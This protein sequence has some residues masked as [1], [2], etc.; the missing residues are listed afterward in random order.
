MRQ[1]R[2]RFWLRAAYA[3]ALLATV[4]FGLRAAWF[5]Y[6][7]S[8]RAEKP[9]AGWMTPRYILAVYEVDPKALAAILKIDPDND[10]RESVARLAAS[11]GLS[12]DSVLREIT[13]LIDA[14]R[15]TP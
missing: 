9:V 13:A 15:D 2:Q 8:E 11:S 3:L 7:L 4:V 12:T 1:K 5:A 10:P 6:E 14:G